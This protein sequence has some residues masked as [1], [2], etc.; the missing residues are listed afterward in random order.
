M[1]DNY[2]SQN[3]VPGLF[4]SQPHIQ[5]ALMTLF[6]DQAGNQAPLNPPSSR[7]DQLDQTADDWGV[8][9][10]GSPTW[11]L[12]HVTTPSL[13]G[14]ALRLAL[15]GGDPYSNAYFYRL[16]SRSPRRLIRGH[17]PVPVQ[18]YHDV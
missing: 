15:T 5:R 17:L 14:N 1:L 3:F 11:D 12:G 18:P 7:S 2:L 13:D 16:F 10:E 4:M 6:P 8:Y 9:V